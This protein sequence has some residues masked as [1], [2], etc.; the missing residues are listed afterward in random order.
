MVDLLWNIMTIFGTQLLVPLIC[1]Y[2]TF[3]F[4]GSLLFNKRQEMIL[5]YILF[6]VF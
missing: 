4:I 2:I 6:L 3:D 1:L 5:C